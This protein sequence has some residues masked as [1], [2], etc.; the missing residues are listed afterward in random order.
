ML[1]AIAPFAF[2]MQALASV[3]ILTFSP[4]SIHGFPAQYMVMPLSLWLTA[5]WLIVWKPE[6]SLLLALVPQFFYGRLTHEVIRVRYLFALK[7]G[8][9]ALLL[10]ALALR[11][12]T[13]DREYVRLRTPL[14]RPMLA[15]GLWIIAM[16]VYGLV[17]GN[18]F[19]DVMTAAHELGQIPVIYFLLTS[20][21]G[22]W[23]RVTNLAVAFGTLNAPLALYNVFAAGRGGGLYSSL[24][25]VPL[26]ALLMHGPKDLKH[27]PLLWVYVY[28]CVL[29]LLLCEHRTL[30]V[31]TGLGLMYLTRT[32]LR[33]ARGIASVVLVVALAVGFVALAQPGGET[34]GSATERFTHGGGRRTAELQ[35]GLGWWYLNDPIFGSFGGGTGFDVPWPNSQGWYPIGPWF[36]NF[37]LTTLFNIGVPG[38]LIYLWLAYSVMLG[39]HVRRLARAKLP[40][41]VAAVVGTQAVYL[42]WL[43]GANFSGPREGHWELGVLPALIGVMATLAAPAGEAVPAKEPETKPALTPATAP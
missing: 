13:G 4:E 17:R 2:A 42:G 32:Y 39:P 11:R 28:I 25:V 9:A 36:H 8:V 33:E 35:L 43:I 12:V 6:L 23:R 18:P 7:V 31:T 30:W 22:D 1:Q 20:V 21:L 29:D 15:Y 34:L 27:R 14:D 37:Y 38:T 24:I 26:F 5:F 19:E 41:Q 3:A 40:G 10:L 16:M